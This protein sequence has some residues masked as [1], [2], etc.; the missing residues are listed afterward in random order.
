EPS[1]QHPRIEIKAVHKGAAMRWAP[2]QTGGRGA[3][4]QRWPPISNFLDT[5]TLVWSL[6][7]HTYSLGRACELY[8]TVYRKSGTGDE[9]HGVITP[10]YVLY[11]RH[12]VLATAELTICGLAHYARYGLSAAPTRLFSPASVTKGML[13]DMG[14]TPRL[15]A[16]RH[17]WHAWHGAAMES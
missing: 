6:T 2:Y 8:Q 7:G 16:E 14:V 3:T 10:E 4:A 1:G 17:F 15:R 9:G 5:S 13:R 12:D 11:N